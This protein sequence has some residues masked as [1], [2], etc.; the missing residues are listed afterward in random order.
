MLIRMLV[1]LSLIVSAALRLLKV[2]EWKG[3]RYMYIYNTCIRT[4]TCIMV[5]A[6]NVACGVLGVAVN[7]YTIIL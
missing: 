1:T 6:P 4:C 2:C 3:V 5:R 7:L